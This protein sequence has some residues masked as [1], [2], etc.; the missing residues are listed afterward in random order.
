MNCGTRAVLRVN[1]SLCLSFSDTDDCNCT[2]PIVQTIIR[3]LPNVSHRAQAPQAAGAG[4]VWEN[5]E[6][7]VIVDGHRRANKCK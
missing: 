3:Y 2:Q 6:D 5:I 1:K 4:N 7:Y